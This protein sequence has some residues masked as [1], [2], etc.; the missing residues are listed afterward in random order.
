MAVVPIIYRHCQSLPRSASMKDQS[1]TIEVAPDAH[2]MQFVENRLRKK[3]SGSEVSPKQRTT[4]EARRTLCVC[5]QIWVMHDSCAVRMKTS[6]DEG[7]RS[8]ALA[9]DV[10]A[11]VS[12][13]YTQVVPT[14]PQRTT[15]LHPQN[16]NLPNAW[17][18][19]CN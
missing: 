12:C 4:T 13:T 7:M 16:C 11:L 9:H 10:H 8:A 18:T 1:E 15:T 17:V 14:T 5:L 2:W 6:P 3:Y 19:G